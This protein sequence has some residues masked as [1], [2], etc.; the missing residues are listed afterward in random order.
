[1]TE[2]VVFDFHDQKDNIKFLPI[3][4]Q[5]DK[6]VATFIHT[7]PNYNIRII[8]TMYKDKC[9]ITRSYN[10]TVEKKEMRFDD[11]ILYVDEFKIALLEKHYVFAS[12]NVIR[13]GEFDGSRMLCVPS[14]DVLDDRAEGPSEGVDGSPPGDCGRVSLEVA[15]GRAPSRVG[16]VQSVW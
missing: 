3:V 2:I 16:R 7:D 12:Q 11:P 4:P 5:Y 1:M 15:S 9:L 10:A 6:P 13:A 8:V 14:L